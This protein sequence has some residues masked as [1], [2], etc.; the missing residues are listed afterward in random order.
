PEDLEALFPE[1]EARRILEELL[2]QHLFLAPAEGG[3]FRYLPLFR[4]YLREKLRRKSREQRVFFYRLAAEH[5]FRN[6]RF[7]EA[8]RLM[9]ETGDAESIGRFLEEHG[10]AMMDRG[11]LNLI[12][13]ALSELSE[14]VKDR[15]YWLWVLEGE[16]N[17]YRCAYARARDCYLRGEGIARERGDFRGVSM[18]LEG[19]ARIFLDTIQP[20]EAERL[21]NRALDVLEGIPGAEEQRSR[22]TR[23]IAENL[24]NYGRADDAG[25]WVAKSRE[26]PDGE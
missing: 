13:K 10:S 16:V 5:A 7:D 11:R 21:L 18:A 9:L 6:R 25:E 17:R 4:D 19:Q 23:L 22:L 15:R 3:R 26:Q 2:R 24:V 8:I 1:A 12:E 20:R 14:E